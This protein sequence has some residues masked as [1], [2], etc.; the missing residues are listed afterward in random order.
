LL[1][2][3][4]CDANSVIKSENPKHSYTMHNPASALSRAAAVKSHLRVTLMLRR[5]KSFW[6]IVSRQ[7]PRFIAW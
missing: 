3:E 5:S 4:P 2:S 7:S 1:P 6:K